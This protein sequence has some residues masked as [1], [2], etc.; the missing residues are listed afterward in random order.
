MNS[1]PSRPREALPNLRGEDEAELSYLANLIETS[2]FILLSSAHPTCV[3]G[4]VPRPP[5]VHSAYCASLY[6][7]GKG[8]IKCLELG[9][10]YG[11]NR[12]DA[13]RGLLERV[14]KEIGSMMV[15]DE[16]KKD[17]ERERERR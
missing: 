7:M 3:L 16:K 17:R 1:L 9:P 2:S 12:K 10:E 6:S 8:G 4:A 15:R 14:E 13:L 11:A 5:D